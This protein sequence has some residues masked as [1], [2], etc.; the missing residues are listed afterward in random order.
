MTKKW[1]LHFLTFS[2]KGENKNVDAKNKAYFCFPIM[3]G[4]LYSYSD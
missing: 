3:V 1:K 2:E 4:I